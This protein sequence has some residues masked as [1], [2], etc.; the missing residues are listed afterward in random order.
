MTF[1]PS[2]MWMSI[3]PSALRCLLD[4]FFLFPL[5]IQTGIA[6]LFA[7]HIGPAQVL[8]SAICY[9]LFFI[10]YLVI[11]C[12]IPRLCDVNKA[13]T[14]KQYVNFRWVAFSMTKSV[15]MYVRMHVLMSVRYDSY[16]ERLWRSKNQKVII[17]AHIF[18]EVQFQDSVHAQNP[19]YRLQIK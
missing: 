9:R 7:L 8:P 14:L 17:E 11:C 10:C 13:S 19:C 6:R 3:T 4:L 18:M 12:L 15:H 16:V 1:V 5:R 2:Y